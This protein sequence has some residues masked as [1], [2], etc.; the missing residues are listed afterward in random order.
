L[1]GAKERHILFSKIYGTRVIYRNFK[2]IC[3]SK[4][5]RPTAGQSITLKVSPDVLTVWSGVKN[6]KLMTSA[7]GKPP[8]K[9]RVINIHTKIMEDYL[10]EGIAV[11]EVASHSGNDFSAVYP[12]PICL[13]KA[14]RPAVGARCVVAG[15]GMTNNLMLRSLMSPIL[16]ILFYTKLVTANNYI[17]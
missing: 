9:Y 15:Y 16:G 3:R 6:G 7:T 4:N 11:L 2:N 17:I 5:R 8:R 12:T 10:W 1:E 14:E 13:P